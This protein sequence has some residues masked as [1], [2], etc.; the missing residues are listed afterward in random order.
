VIAQFHDRDARGIPAAWIARLRESM[1]RL[2]P[3][4][5][6]NRTVREYA[7]RHYL[8]AATA[9]RERAAGQGALGAHIANWR[10]TLDEAGPALRFGE[11]KIDSDGDRHSFEVQV[12]LGE[13]DPDAV[14]VELYADGANGIGPAEVTVMR[15]QHAQVPGT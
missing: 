3:R 1:A 4:Y 8:P 9:Y 14:G 15:L 12:H 5:S 13:L 6:A 11:M 7:E 2:T 10:R